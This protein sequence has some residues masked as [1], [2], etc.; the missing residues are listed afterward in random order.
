[1]SNARIALA[2]PSCSPDA[3]TA[4]EVLKQADPATVRCGECGHT[5]K[6]SLPEDDTVERQVVVSQ[7]G[8]SF[9]ARHEADPDDRLVVGDEFLLDAPEALMQ[10]RVTSLETAEGREDGAAISDIETIWTRAVENVAVDVTLHPQDG[11]REET[12]SVTLRIPGDEQFMVDETVTYGDEEFTIQGLVVRDDAVGYDR[13]QFD[14]TGDA[15]LAKD[16]K[17][18]YARD[19]QT[20]AWSAW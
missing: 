20:T 13:Q 3:P 5:H 10:V 1:M 6:E 14:Y 15:V 19:E 12:R 16:L 2:C 8:E 18:V 17:R 9:T 4:H 11:K 7:D